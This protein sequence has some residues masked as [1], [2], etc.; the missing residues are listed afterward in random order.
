MCSGGVDAG[1]QPVY[2]R[3]M[4]TIDRKRPLL[5]VSVSQTVRSA[6]DTAARSRGITLSGYVELVMRGELPPPMVKGAA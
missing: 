5:T 6:V 3:G 2:N 1:C 4:E